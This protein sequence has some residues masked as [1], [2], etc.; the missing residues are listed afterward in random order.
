MG[1]GD[2]RG[3][4]TG[5]R[6]T[7]DAGSEGNTPPPMSDQD[8]DDYRMDLVALRQE[9]EEMLS[10]PVLQTQDGFRRRREWLRV[11]AKAIDA[12]ERAVARFGP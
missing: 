12:L 10:R 2:N 11:N 5:F 1:G 8:L 7:G 3:H 9:R 4:G 6:V